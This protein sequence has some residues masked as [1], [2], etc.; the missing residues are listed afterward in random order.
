MFRHAIACFP[1]RRQ[2]TIVPMKHSRSPV[3]TGRFPI[4]SASPIVMLAGLFAAGT[5]F[6]LAQGATTAALIV[7]VDGALIIGYAT[8]RRA[9]HGHRRRHPSP[10]S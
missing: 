5:L 3:Q 7:A 2:A 8:A 6:L 4:R 1:K 10:R 9:G